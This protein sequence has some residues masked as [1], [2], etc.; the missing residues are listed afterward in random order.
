MAPIHR[1]TSTVQARRLCPSAPRVS[2]RA[3][4]A[5]LNHIWARLCSP[6]RLRPATVRRHIVLRGH[7]SSPPSWRAARCMISYIIRPNI[8][9]YSHKGCNMQLKDYQL[10]AVLSVI[11]TIGE[12]D[13]P[14]IDYGKI[15]N[16][17]MN[18]SFKV[19]SYDKKAMIDNKPV[20]KMQFEND[21]TLYT[22]IFY[23]KDSHPFKVELYKENNL[24]F[25]T[26]VNVEFEYSNEVQDGF[27]FY[28]L[29]NSFVYNLEFDELP[30]ELLKEVQEMEL[31][32]S[33]EK[34]EK[35]RQKEF[36]VNSSKKLDDLNWSNK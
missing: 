23:I 17:K 29:E 2:L 8:I 19:I 24:V 25:F 27:F 35:E 5:P 12:Y 16:E 14:T 20:K 21:G 3:F 26:K 1:L 28:K 18:H 7:Y 32:H 36:E 34:W 13:F 22:F 31:A 15:Y 33:V 9:S 4:R 10:K 30:F 6:K 11:H